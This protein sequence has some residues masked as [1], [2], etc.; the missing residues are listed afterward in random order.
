M[1]IIVRALA[2]ASYVLLMMVAV[3]WSS[4]AHAEPAR[5][6]ES[7]PEEQ[8]SREGTV[9]VKVAPR[10]LAPSAQSWDFEI[11]LDTHTQPLT[12][13][14]VGATAL[15]DAAGNVHTPIGWEGD[16]PGGHH[17][18]GLLRFQPPTGG[19]GVVEL[20]MKA[21]GGIPVRVFRW[22]PR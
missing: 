8:T 2:G 1:K 19:Q 6:F 16:P 4:N 17:R 20:R 3:P 21:I 14:L 13:D 15:I 7:A 22:Q 9:M 11:T 10:S 12:Q 18:Q 5:D